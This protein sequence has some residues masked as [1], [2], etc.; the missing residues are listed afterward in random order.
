MSELRGKVNRQ[1]DKITFK[2]RDWNRRER[3][4]FKVRLTQRQTYL[5]GEVVRHT[6]KVRFAPTGMSDLQGEVDIRT[7]LP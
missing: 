1:G 6:F 7:D 2:V 5:Q 4:I 3:L